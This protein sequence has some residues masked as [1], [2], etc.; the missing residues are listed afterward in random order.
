M[1]KKKI[2][3]NTKMDKLSKKMCAAAD[4]T[5]MKVLMILSEKPTYVYDLR[6]KVSCEPTLLSHHLSVL[7]ENGLAK[8]Q[9]EGKFVLYTKIPGAISAEDLEMIFN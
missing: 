5:R 4:I 3:R 6:K 9:R 2:K 1:I 7:K 8:A